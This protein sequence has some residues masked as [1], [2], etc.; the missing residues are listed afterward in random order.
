MLCYSGPSIPGNFASKRKNWICVSAGF[1]TKHPDRKRR[2]VPSQSLHYLAV[3]WVAPK[4]TFGPIER[5]LN[6][7]SVRISI[8]L[9][10]CLLKLSKVIFLMG[11]FFKSWILWFFMGDCW[12]LEEWDKFWAC[13]FKPRKFKWDPEWW[14][15][16]IIRLKGKKSFCKNHHSAWYLQ[17]YHKGSAAKVNT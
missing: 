1:W 15:S 9:F 8:T 3:K 10:D 2:S 14:P 6:D 12:M 7:L 16:G 4:I 17:Y 13:P 5:L 11:C